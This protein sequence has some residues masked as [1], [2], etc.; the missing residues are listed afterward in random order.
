MNGYSLK[1]INNN[2]IPK[3][4]KKKRQSPLGNC[5]L[6]DGQVIDKGKFFGCSNYQKKNCTFTLSK[7]ILGKSMTQKIVKQLLKSGETDVLEG[8]QGKD[9][10]FA[11][12][13]MWDK[14]ENK[15]KFKFPN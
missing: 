11:A 4:F 3:T 7:K 12:A 5:Q 6:C 13:L 10:L 14:K 15:I 1:K 2:F 8:F 9:K